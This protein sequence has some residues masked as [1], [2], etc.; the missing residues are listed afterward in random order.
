[1][2]IYELVS[3]FIITSNHDSCASFQKVPF[4]AHNTAI[5][6]FRVDVRMFSSRPIQDSR[7]WNATN[8]MYAIV[9][10][11]YLADIRP[12]TIIRI[13]LVFSIVVPSCFTFVLRCSKAHNDLFQKISEA[14]AKACTFDSPSI[15]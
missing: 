10:S 3:N 13:N 2:F 5:Q 7:S 15:S 14:T 8:K 12:T 1:M 6:M 9:G 11:L 4:N